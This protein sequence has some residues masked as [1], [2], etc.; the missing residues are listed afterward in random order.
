[1]DFG[2]KCGDSNELVPPPPRGVRTDYEQLIL[3]SLRLFSLSA[4]WLLKGTASLT[5]V[6]NNTF[7][8][9]LGGCLPGINNLGMANEK[10]L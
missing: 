10:K 6:I 2:K 1:V 8:I 5:K 4:G 9:I 3:T 7:I